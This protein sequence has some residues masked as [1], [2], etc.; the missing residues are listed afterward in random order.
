MAGWS[1]DRV[2]NLRGGIHEWSDTIDS[3]IPKY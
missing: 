3:S 1:E 2:Y